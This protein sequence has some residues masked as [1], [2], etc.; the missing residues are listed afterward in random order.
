MA[1]TVGRTGVEME[2][3]TAASVPVADVIDALEGGMI[4]SSWVTTMIAVSILARH[5]V[6]DAHDG[7]RAFAVE[8]RGRLVGEDHRRLIGQ[9]AGDGDALLFAAGKLRRLARARCADV[10]R[11]Q[12][13]PRPLA[14]LRRWRPASIGSRATLS[15]TSRKGSGRAPGNTKPMRSRRSARRSRSSSRC[16]RSPRRRAVMRPAVGSI[17]APRH[18]SSVLLPEP[19]GPISPTPRPAHGHVDVLQRVDGGIARAVALAQTFDADAEQPDSEAH[20]SLQS[21]WPGPPCS[22]ARM[23]RVLAMAQISMTAT[24]PRTASPGSSSTYLGKI[25]RPQRGGGLADHENRSSPA[26]AP[27]A[28]SSRRWCGCACRSA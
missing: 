24:K 25:R 18:L 6:E 17:T 27:A 20:L 13:F 16:R 3:L 7:Q 23:A 10:E 4:F 5:A 28:G 21:R 8:R 15:V 22:A 1:E 26:P 2:A 11:R 19:L 9:R 14:R 12:Q